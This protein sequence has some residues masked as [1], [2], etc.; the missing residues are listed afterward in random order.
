MLQCQILWYHS[1]MIS[2]IDL[3]VY[4]LATFRA[5][6]LISEDDLPYNLGIKM[7]SWLSRKAKAEPA[8]RKS[9]VHK[10][11]KCRRCS[12]VW[13]AGILAFV[14]LSDALQGILVIKWGVLVLAL[15]GLAILL[16][17]VPE[18]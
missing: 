15:S 12:S 13:V 11:V 17:R 1:V 4:G 2:W 10:G 18:N 3:M 7:R 9:A 6:L 16:A 5:S 8:V 14:V